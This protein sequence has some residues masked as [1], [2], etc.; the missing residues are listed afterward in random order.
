MGD[1]ISYFFKHY[2]NEPLVSVNLKQQRGGGVLYPEGIFCS[3][4]M[5]L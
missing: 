2:G 3:R 1:T 4:L 5:G